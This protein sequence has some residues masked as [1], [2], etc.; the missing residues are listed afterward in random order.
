MKYW[1]TNRSPDRYRVFIVSANSHR[2]VLNGNA[3]ADA[4]RKK[5]EAYPGIST[6]NLSRVVGSQVRELQIEVEPFS[7]ATLDHS[8]MNAEF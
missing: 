4:L 6:F 2:N 3:T 1:K 5:L 7:A 8:F